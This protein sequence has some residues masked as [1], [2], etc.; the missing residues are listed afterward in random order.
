LTIRISLL[1]PVRVHC[2]GKLVDLRAAKPKSLLAC[3]LA[4][5]HQVITV[6]SLITEL[7]GTSPPSSAAANL[8]TYIAAIRGALPGIRLRAVHQ[9]YLVEMAD[10]DVDAGQFRALA[11][12]GR[13]AAARGETAQ[14]ARLLEQ[15]E[16]LWRGDAL[17]DINLG[18]ILAEFAGQLA[19]ERVC[20]VEEAIQARLDLGMHEEVL[21]VARAHAHQN[22]LRERAQAQLMLACYRAGDIVGALEVHRLAREALRDE[23][24]LEPGPQLREIHHKVLRRDPLLE[25]KAAS[26]KAEAP[27]VMAEAG[28]VLAQV[29][30]RQLC[31]HGVSTFAISLVAQ[32]LGSSSG[33]ARWVASRLC[34]QQLAKPIGPD[35][36]CLCRPSAA[37]GPLMRRSAPTARL[38]TF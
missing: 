24:G 30:Y 17:A 33:L 1:G 4:R 14:A 2:D 8:R 28:D 21:P 6:D 16:A 3:L 36:F 18:A 9:G 10:D 38:T 12:L 19:E 27:T 11:R 22:P 34:T 31:D 13:A 29:V 23:L 25:P 15:A 35:Q 32:V 20:V 37:A 5:A 7:W 26:V